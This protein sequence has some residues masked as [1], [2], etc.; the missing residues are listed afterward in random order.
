MTYPRA[1][2]TIFSFFVFVT[3]GIASE[4]DELREKARE[5]E[6]KA[7]ELAE[8]GQGEKAEHFEREA[9]ELYKKADYHER[10]HHERKIMELKERL[11][12][13]QM[14]ERELQEHGTEDEHL[15]DLRHEIE[16]VKSHL[17]EMVH[18]HRDD[19]RGPDGDI[20]R[21]L[22]HMRA[23]AEHLHHAGLH[24][25]S[26][27][28]IQRI[29]AVER[30]LHHHRDHH[31]DNPIHAI[32]RQLEEMRHEMSRLREELNDLRESR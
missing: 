27:H 1:T 31:E 12:K 13:L 10:E 3:I 15:D 26:N 17:H 11:E 8:S 5:I 29:H 20:E 23:A 28:V 30:E 6:R 32:M 18:T 7:A 14:E 16:R 2:L 25:V 21:R 19:H 22:K 9:A 4:S 24:D